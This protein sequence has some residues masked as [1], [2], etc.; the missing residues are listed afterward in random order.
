MRDGDLSLVST[1]DNEI[2]IRETEADTIFTYRFTFQPIINAELSKSTGSNTN[3]WF[4]RLTNFSGGAVKNSSILKKV[5]SWDL[6]P[7]KGDWVAVKPKCN[8]QF[9]G[10]P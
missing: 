3:R 8:M 4:H 7:L 2:V 1:G 6:V 10:I 5:I 9:K